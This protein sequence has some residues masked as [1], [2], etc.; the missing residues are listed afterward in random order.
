MIRKRDLLYGHHLPFN[1]ND[2]VT[3]LFCDNCDGEFIF[4]GMSAE[5]EAKANPLTGQYF[6]S[7]LVKFCPFCG[8]RNTKPRPVAD[9][10]S[11]V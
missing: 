9:G 8:A 6:Q 10:S 7:S 5:S 11:R 2:F 3:W 1:A 4:A